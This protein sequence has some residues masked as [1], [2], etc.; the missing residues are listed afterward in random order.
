VFHDHV[1]G[2]DV[3]PDGTVVALDLRQVVRDRVARVGEAG[4]QLRRPLD[5]VIGAPSPDAARVPA[6]VVELE[7]VGEDGSVRRPVARVDREGEATEQLDQCMALAGGSHSLDG[8]TVV[9]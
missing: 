1:L 9:M 6:R 7:F 4:E 5:P 8:I 3:G 2:R